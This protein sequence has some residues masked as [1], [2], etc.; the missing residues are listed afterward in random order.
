MKIV[1]L[2]NKLTIGGKQWFVVAL[3]KELKRKGFDVEVICFSGLGDLAK[4]LEKEGIEVG[5]KKLRKHGYDPFAIFSF[6]SFVRFLKAQKGDIFHVHG[7]PPLMRVGLAC[8]AA[9]VPFVVQYHS[10]HP[11]YDKKLWLFF[12]RVVL[13]KALGVIYITYAVKRSVVRRCFF[14]KDGKMIYN[15]TFRRP[16]SSKKIYDLVWVARF[17]SQKRP[18]DFVELVRMLNEKVMVRAVMV[19]GGDLFEEVSKRILGLPIK[20]TGFM[21]DPERFLAASDCGI[22][23]SER[24]GFSIT[25]AEYL[26]FGLPVLAYKIP[27]LIEVVVEKC[28][29]LVP[30]G[31]LRNMADIFLK[32]KSNSK[33]LK[34]QSVNSRRRGRLFSKDA[35][36]ESY[37]DFYEG[38]SV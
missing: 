25:A 30:L 27:A 12:E 10:V 11:P 15:A 22:V 36:V 26:S 20:L 8:I 31:Q 2:T 35:M 14:E 9:G 13:S 4:D 28:G 5:C 37:K 3:A 38:Y 17:S 32:L 24:E 33:L 6:F 21:K 1:H 29:K 18:L 23:T 19:G 7:Y 16:F 34:K